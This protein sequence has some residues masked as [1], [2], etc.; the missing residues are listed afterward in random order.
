VKW[1]RYDET[2]EEQSTR[3]LGRPVWNDQEYWSLDLFQQI[4]GPCTVSLMMI[5][6]Y[7]CRKGSTWRQ[8]LGSLS[9]CKLAAQFPNCRESTVVAPKGVFSSKCLAP[10]QATASINLINDTPPPRWPVRA[11][12]AP[13]NP[14]ERSRKP[15]PAPADKGS[16]GY[17]A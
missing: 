2:T 1:I 15:L 12:I 16:K 3:A 9:Q 17:V 13:P 11:L 6:G 14:E 10:G 7:C 8:L 5:D 4:P